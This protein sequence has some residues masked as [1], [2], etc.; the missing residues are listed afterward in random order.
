MKRELPRETGGGVSSSQDPHSTHG[1]NSFS[2][3]LSNSMMLRTNAFGLV[4]FTLG[5]LFILGGCGGNQ[6][7]PPP[8][9]TQVQLTQVDNQTVRVSWQGSDAAVSYNVYRSTSSGTSVESM[10]PRNAASPVSET[11]FLDTET[12]NTTTYYYRITA[13]NEGGQ[14]EPSEEREITTPYPAPP[15]RP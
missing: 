9:P 1:F 15:D 8:A 14:S 3:D 13:E 4:L 7:S 11:Q 6:V 12:V 10:T 2:Q 5:L